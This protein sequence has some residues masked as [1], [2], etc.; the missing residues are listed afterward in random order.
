M[1]RRLR[2]A[3]LA[4][5]L[6]LYPLESPIASQEVGVSMVAAGSRHQ[7][8]PSPEGLSAFALVELSPDWLVRVSFQR[9]SD[10]TVKEGLVCVSYSPRIGCGPQETRTSTSL[11]GL[12][13]GILRAFAFGDRLRVGA[14]GGLSF[15]QVDTRATG[16]S[17]HRADLLH[18]TGGQLGAFGLL[19]VAMAPYPAIP[20]RIVAGLAAHWVDFRACSGE[21]PPQYDPFCTSGAFR[22]LEVGLS[23]AF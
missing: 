12:R 17:G 9:V 13:G 11:S 22:E 2:L 4:V 19:S 6:A 20:V 16:V 10:V 7:E 23:Y 5:L 21:T 1:N 14:G 3:L 15:N 8:L 18:P